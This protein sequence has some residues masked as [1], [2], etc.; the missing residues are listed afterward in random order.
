ME[1]PGYWV[2]EDAGKAFLKRATF[3]ATELDPAA[4]CKQAWHNQNGE[5]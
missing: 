4:N 3:D 1:F 2:S 5:G